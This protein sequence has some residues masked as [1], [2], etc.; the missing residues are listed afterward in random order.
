MLNWYGLVHAIPKQWRD[1]IC[2]KGLRKPGVFEYGMRLSN[3]FVSISNITSKH[4]YSEY[5]NKMNIEPL[6][7]NYL[8]RVFG[9]TNDQCSNIFILPFNVTLDTKLRWFQY[10]VIHNILPTNAWLKKV[11]IIENEMCTFCHNDNETITHMFCDCNKVTD[12]WRLIQNRINLMKGIVA[13]D[14]LYGMTDCKKVNYLVI[15]HILILFKK[16]VYKCRAD[17]SNFF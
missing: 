1:S 9:M 8:K 2:I 12:F 13:F 16:Y 7:Q 15:N 10:R 14:I 17:Q 6:S 4:L 5:M 11:G 3:G